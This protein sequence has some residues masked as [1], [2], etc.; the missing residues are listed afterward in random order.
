MHISYEFNEGEKITREYGYYDNARVANAM[1]AA[2][3]GSDGL[4]LI[5]EHKIKEGQEEA[6]MAA[7]Q[8]WKNM[9][10]EKKAPGLFT[11]IRDK[12]LL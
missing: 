7:Y 3:Y 8:S 11:M 10:D 12:R 5:R 6:Y 9:L 4:I 2:R 1:A